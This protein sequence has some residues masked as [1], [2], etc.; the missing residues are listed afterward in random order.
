M[1]KKPSTTDQLHI[2][3]NN[4][5]SVK[6]QIS[7][8]KKDNQNVVLRSK[9][10]FDFDVVYGD[11]D[12]INRHILSAFL[13]KQDRMLKYQ[14]SILKLN[15]KYPFNFLCTIDFLLFDVSLIVNN[16][17]NVA[18]MVGCGFNV[19]LVLL[20]LEYIDDICDELNHFFKIYVFEETMTY[21][22]WPV[23]TRCDVDI[24]TIYS[25]VYHQLSQEATFEM[26]KYYSK[27]MFPFYQTTITQEMMI[28]EHRRIMSQKT[29]E[30]KISV[31]NMKK[32]DRFVFSLFKHEMNILEGYLYDYII[33]NP[34]TKKMIVLF[35]FIAKL[36]QFGIDDVMK[37][38]YT[39]GYNRA[40]KTISLSSTICNY[41][42][43][44]EISIDHLNINISLLISMPGEGLITKTIY[45]N[46][47]VDKNDNNFEFRSFKSHNK[48]SFCMVMDGSKFEYND[49]KNLITSNPDDFIEAISIGFDNKSQDM[50]INT[51]MIT[52]SNESNQSNV[53]RFVFLPQS[54]SGFVDQKCNVI[55]D[56][57]S[58]DD[59]EKYNKQ[60]N[61]CV[62]T[63][64][65][66]TSKSQDFKCV[67][68]GEIRS[69]D[70]DGCS[71]A[72]L[73]VDVNISPSNSKKY[74]LKI[75]KLSIH[76]LN[77]DFLL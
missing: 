54:R 48:G 65:K 37:R 8:H 26:M 60:M 11:P 49:Q 5:L 52:F 46:D 75:N 63:F 77:S 30:I 28:P 9:I 53:K 64:E 10:P 50:N 3:N 69:L 61:G 51:A 58:H 13:D 36:L 4:I 40:E 25:S 35:I 45:L 1:I 24:S 27:H 20:I 44:P 74:Y 55:D 47:F 71:K 6:K 19:D 21:L 32:N 22:N 2:L 56:D 67:F 33:Y 16:S 72:Q 17:N 23:E 76:V 38:K 70:M 7:K 73:L 15:Q 43:I 14:E 42:A 59:L 62:N 34:N 29:K 66:M 41:D 12:R 57:F 31:S 39:F 68:N 18:K